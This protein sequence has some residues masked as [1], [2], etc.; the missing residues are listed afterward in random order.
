MAQLLSQSA[1]DRYREVLA[2][3][4]VTHSEDALYRC[5][6]LSKELVE[7]GLG[8]ED[9]LALHVESLGY[10]VQE[11]TPI[12]QIRANDLA[13]QFLLEV[14]IAYGVHYRQYLEMRM[15]EAVRNAEEQ[16]QID[17][18]RVVEAER[19]GREREEILAM[20][21]H[22]L[23]TPI[24][25]A[26]TSIE[27]AEVFASRGDAERI[28]SQLERAREGL[29][30]LSRLSADLVEASRGE[31]PTLAWTRIDVSQIVEQACSWA[32]PA[33]AAK[34]VALDVEPQQK[35]ELIVTANPDALLSIFGNLISNGVRYTPA[36]GSVTARYG[37]DDECVWFEVQD[38]GIGISQEAQARIFE[39]FYRAPEARSIETRGLGLGLALVKQMVNA[40]CGAVAVS[41]APG[42]GSTFRV[43][44][45]R[46]QADGGPSRG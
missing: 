37:A 12:E 1:P 4:L 8:P 18:E 17:R 32:Q 10:A 29:H 19:L 11:L 44:I 36:G 9:I 30:R 35:G 2:D 5:S 21:A 43:T 28:P 26:M 27:L 40:H 33:A 24:T 20:I 14:M 13:H 15:Q 7:N 45:P 22:E 16:A 3:F 39:K 6:L 31:P 34:G 41:S 42:A 46:Q 38:T 25:A 23:R